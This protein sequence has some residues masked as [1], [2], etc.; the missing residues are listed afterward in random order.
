MTKALAPLLAS[1]ST[2][3]TLIWWA[4]GD[5]RERAIYAVVGIG[6]V[7]VGLTIH[8]VISATKPNE[9]E[10]IGEGP[11]ARHARRPSSSGRT[12]PLAPSSSDGGAPVTFMASDGFS[13]CGSGGSD[14][15][16]CGGGDA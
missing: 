3:L 8:F 1:F 2:L 7:V 5:V 12:R 6:V 10:D 16:S 15:G 11:R 13:D 4:E 14:G 9:I